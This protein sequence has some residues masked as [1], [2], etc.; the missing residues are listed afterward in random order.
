MLL[1]NGKTATGIPIRPEVMSLLAGGKRPAVILTFNGYTHGTTVGS[2]EGQPM[3]PISATVRGESGVKAGDELEI[4]IALNTQP[5]E[6]AIPAGLAA[7]LAAEPAARASF[8]AL[9]Y[10]EKRWHVLPIDDAKTE[11]TRQRRIAKSLAMLREGHR[12]R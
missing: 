7:A 11:E 6:V 2:V 3:L 10:S 5:R 12:P 1:S 8:E 4:E 9:N